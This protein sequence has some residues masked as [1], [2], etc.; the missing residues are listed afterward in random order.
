MDYIRLKE[1]TDRVAQ[2]VNFLVGSQ[3]FVNICVKPV[4]KI[5]N[6]QIQ[7][8]HV[9]GGYRR[10]NSEEAAEKEAAE[11]EAVEKEAVEKE[12]ARKKENVIAKKIQK[13]DIERR[14]KGD[15]ERRQK[16]KIK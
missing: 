11:K 2:N 5:S 1:K 3:A 14:Q 15:I 12:E 9:I 16:E 4:V 6:Q 8:N 10:R 7:K 13:G